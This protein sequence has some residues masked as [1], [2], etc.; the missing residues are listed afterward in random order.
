[1]VIQILNFSRTRMA[2]RKTRASTYLIKEPNWKEL[3]LLTSE[4]ERE[5]SYQDCYY[6][7]HQEIQSK[8]LQKHMKDW[9]KLSSGW[10]KKDIKNILSIPDCYFSTSGKYA[11]I[12]KKLG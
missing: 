3:A 8:N 11:F 1:M 9:I 5:K 4:Q 10:D 12:C 6:F 7:V 2:K